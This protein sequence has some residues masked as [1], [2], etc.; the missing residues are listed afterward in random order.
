M[1]Q[2][3]SPIEYKGRVW[4]ELKLLV[5]FNLLWRKI[6]RPFPCRIL[7]SLL[8]PL[9]LIEEYEKNEGDMDIVCMDGEIQKCHSCVISFQSAIMRRSIENNLGRAQLNCTKF[10]KPTMAK[11]LQIMYCRDA[12][13]T[14]ANEMIEVSYSKV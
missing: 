2:R 7:E 14:Y 13:F 12:E 5:C 9:E 10:S 11:L 3:Y 1:S 4:S 6:L 8:E